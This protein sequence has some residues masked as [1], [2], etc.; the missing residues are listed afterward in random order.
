M[1]CAMLYATAVYNAM[2]TC[3]AQTP[4]KKIDCLCTRP[5]ICLPISASS[6]VV[7]PSASISL[8]RTIIK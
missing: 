8:R 2:H 7:P 6:A 5:S 1:P 4:C 3:C